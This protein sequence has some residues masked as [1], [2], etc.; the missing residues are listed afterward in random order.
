M[1]IHFLKQ[2]DLP[3][4]NFSRELVGDEEERHAFVDSGSDRLRQID[5]HLS[6]RFET[7]WLDTK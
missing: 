5:V 3:A 1:S 2:S 6:S 7:V 4:S